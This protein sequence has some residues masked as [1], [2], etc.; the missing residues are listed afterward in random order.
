MRLKGP[1]FPSFLNQQTPAP[2]RQW[3]SH[4]G[5]RAR[6]RNL[7]QMAKKE[8]SVSSKPIPF[9]QA[10]GL[11]VVGQPFTIVSTYCPITATL[12]CNCGGAEA[13]T[14]VSIVNSVAA[15]CPSCHKSYNLGLN[16]TD[17]KIAVHIG[18]PPAEQV[19]S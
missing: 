14:T 10:A 16:P 3:V 19:P 12:R 1:V 2:R 15:P 17:G 6:C 7:A 8:S 18:V 9:P 4:T 5:A 13:E 11:P